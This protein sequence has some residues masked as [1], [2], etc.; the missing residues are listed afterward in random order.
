MREPAACKDG[1]RTVGR[2]PREGL[3]R[4]ARRRHPGAPRRHERARGT[5]RCRCPAAAAQ[6]PGWPLARCQQPTRP[7][8][9]RSAS[10]GAAAARHRRSTTWSSPS[11]GTAPA[12]PTA[13]RTAAWPA[14]PRSATATAL[15][16]ARTA[17]SD[18]TST[19]VR[20]AFL[21]CP[22]RLLSTARG[23]VGAAVLRADRQPSAGPD[24][25]RDLLRPNLP[26]PAARHAAGMCRKSSQASCRLLVISMSF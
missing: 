9:S 20:C 22:E 1:R 17:V 2:V 16:R 11:H 6:A 26:P 3:V 15:A 7:A 4:G 8:A 25:H 5:A 12:S 21:A 18:S 23:H 10:A 24:A 14:P 19:P 13:G